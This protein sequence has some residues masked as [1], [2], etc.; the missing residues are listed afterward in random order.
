MPE[1]NHRPPQ[2]VIFVMTSKVARTV[3]SGLT[4][5]LCKPIRE[6]PLRVLKD[7]ADG[8]INAGG[9]DEHPIRVGKSYYGPP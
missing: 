7:N 5:M 8:R 3:T 2:Q 4:I 9:A 6:W 1:K